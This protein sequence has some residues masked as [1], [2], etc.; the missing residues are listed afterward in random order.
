MADSVLWQIMSEV[1]RTLRENLTFKAMG[2][3]PIPQIEQE[4]I[5]IEK[6]SV[7]QREHEKV[8]EYELTPGIIITP[9]GRVTM[10]SSEGENARDDVHYP[11]LLQIIDKDNNE[12]LTGLRTYLKWQEQ[13]A[14]AFRNQPLPCDPLHVWNARVDYV[15]VVNEGLWVRHELFVT[16]IEIEFISREVRGLA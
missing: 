1:Q 3:D 10:P 5:R 2:D 9:P 16:G 14:R 11:L 13:I 15:D 4:A 7:K 12:R 8:F 6:V